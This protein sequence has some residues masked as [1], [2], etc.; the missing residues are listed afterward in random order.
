MPHLAAMLLAFAAGVGLAAQIPLNVQLRHGVGHPTLSA[1]ASFTLGAALLGLYVLAARV[2]WPSFAQVAQIPWWAWL[3]G[4]L[5]ACY[6][7][8]TIVLGP[9][10][11]AG[12]FVTL[13]VAGQLAAALVIDHQGWLGAAPQPVNAW[14]VAGAGLALLG[15]VLIQRH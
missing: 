4:T 6:V 13:V 12:L 14:R 7:S 2:P 10:L 5:G 11:G 3:G 8:A 1:F 15:V 9:K